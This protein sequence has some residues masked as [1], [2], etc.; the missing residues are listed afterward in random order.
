MAFE[1]Y[2]KKL[3]RG[4]FGPEVHLHKDGII[5]VNDVAFKQL[6][7]SRYV[8]MLFNTS[9]GEVGIRPAQKDADTYSLHPKSLVIYSRKFCKDLDIHLG[10][11]SLV[12]VAEMREK[13][14]VFSPR[15]NEASFILRGNR[16]AIMNGK[17]PATLQN[18]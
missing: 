1:I 18:V 17:R 14:L 3:K 16:E 11:K 15:L 10:D 4:G 9:T 12:Y 2:R 13:M 8:H 7:G 5:K 6:N